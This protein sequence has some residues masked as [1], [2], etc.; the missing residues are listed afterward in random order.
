MI[1]KIERVEI[2][3]AN[4][5]FYD[6]FYISINDLYL[7]SMNDIISRIIENDKKRFIT[8][9]GDN[10]MMDYRYSIVT[11][12]NSVDEQITPLYP[13]AYNEHGYLYAIK[14][15]ETGEL[16]NFKLRGNKYFTRK[17]DAEA[18]CPNKGY[19]VVQLAVHEI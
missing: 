12:E 7:Y 11:P 9:H 6:K 10:P 5:E 1:F 17:Q 19:E 4:Y 16:K 14:D 15:I 13:I 3:N 2:N 18:K 8:L